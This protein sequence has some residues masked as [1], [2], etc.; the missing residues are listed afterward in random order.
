MLRTSLRPST[1]VNPLA[2]RSLL[3][4]AHLARWRGFAVGWVEATPEL[5]AH[6]SDEQALLL[7]MLDT[8]HAQ[9]DFR[10]GR[11]VWRH[12][13]HADDLGL[14]APRSHA[15]LSH[16]RCE[17]VRRIMLRIDRRDLEDNTLAEGLFQAP[18][19]TTLAF[20]DPSLAAV[21]RAMASEIAA[22]CPNGALFAESLSLGV[23]MRLQQRSPLGP[24]AARGRLQATEL[25]R[26][27]DL[28]RARVA[29]GLSISDMAQAVGLSR[30]QFVRQFKLSAGCTPYQFVL[31][32]RLQ[33]ARTHVLEGRL[34]LAEVAQLVG[35]SSQSHMTV[36]FQRTWGQTPG[37]LRRSNQRS[38][39]SADDDAAQGAPPA[40]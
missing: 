9:A 8:G 40:V 23:A 13:L 33:M 26:L 12:A 21:L 19:P 25:D 24:V 2:E 22:G 20:R 18:L 6:G 7:A 38:M 14:F 28:V 39:G 29:K 10:F 16:W 3:S 15:D 35:F 34:P 31:K 11:R 37:E 5:V 1:E 30:A 17:G 36:L 32:T 27:Q 4:A